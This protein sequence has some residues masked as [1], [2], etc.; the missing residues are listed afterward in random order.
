MTQRFEYWRK[1][2]LFAL[3]VLAVLVGVLIATPF[4]LVLATPFI[5]GH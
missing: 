5:A 3:D 4:I 1:S 2:T